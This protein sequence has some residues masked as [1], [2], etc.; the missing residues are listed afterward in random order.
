MVNDMRRRFKSKRRYNIGI[1]FWLFLFIFIVFVNFFLL[2]N[3]SF[4]SIYTGRGK[5]IDLNIDKRDVLMKIGFNRIFKNEEVKPVSSEV[6]SKQNKKIYIYNTHQTEE[7]KDYD[8]YEGSK[9][10]KELLI[11]K[12]FDVVLEESNVKEVLNDNDWSYKDSYK[13]TREFLNKSIKNDFDLYIDFHR[14]SSSKDV[15]TVLINDKNYARLMFVIGAKH[16]TYTNNYELVEVLN[17]YLKN[18]NN[19][20]TRGIYVR[21]SS[22]YNQDLDPNIILIEVG[23]P[24]NTREEVNNSLEILSDVIESY[25]Y[26]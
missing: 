22:S 2:E 3:V 15:S 24:E 13:V 19:K 11:K 6:V 18:F 8:V 14:D 4:S 25:Y 26:E 7:Y 10:L 21:K 17:K 1:Y 5:I 20:I 23:G 12:G 9:Y 16:E